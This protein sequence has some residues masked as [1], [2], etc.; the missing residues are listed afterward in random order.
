MEF[1]LTGKDTGSASEQLPDA[2]EIRREERLRLAN[3][4][5]KMAAELESESSKFF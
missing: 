4:L 2:N 3:R 5:K 1:L